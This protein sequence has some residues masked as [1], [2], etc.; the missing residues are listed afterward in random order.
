MVEKP[1]LPRAGIQVPEI[2]A[3]SN[4]LDARLRGHD[5]LW[6]SFS[7]GREFLFNSKMITLSPHGREEGDI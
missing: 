3:V 7:G 1:S 2:V 5:E 4:F 6:H